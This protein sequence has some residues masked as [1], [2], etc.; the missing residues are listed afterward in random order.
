M[1]EDEKT[2]RS[3]ENFLKAVY[4]L[5]QQSERENSEADSEQEQRVSTN[6]LSEA[7]AIA[8]PSVTDMARRMVDANLID[9]QRYYGVRLTEEGEAIA[10]R[11]IRRH[12]LIELYLV[13]E[14][15]YTLLDVHDEAE[16]LEH[17]VSDKF[18][19][20]LEAKL[21]YPKVDPHGDPIPNAEGVMTRANTIPLRDL[22]PG[23]RGRVS[24][25]IAENNEMLQYIMERNFNLGAE[26]EVIQHDP[27]QGPLTVRVDDTQTIIGH[28]VA[29][30][31]LV[32]IE[33]G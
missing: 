19:M 4:V 13:E 11:V 32:E 23:R 16:E 30:C 5:Q 7:L 8:P 22:P 28:L 29:A 25:L 1:S 24:R 9:Y 17:V 31:I 6:A 14:L 26:V 21:G 15:G 33:D 2:S 10:L 18:I 27:F 20:A 3:V 12:R